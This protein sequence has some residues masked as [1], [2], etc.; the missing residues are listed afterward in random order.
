MRSLLGASQTPLLI[1]FGAALRDEVWD[2][3]NPLL[4]PETDNPEQYNDAVY[5]TTTK[6]IV[7]PVS[8]VD[9]YGRLL[10]YHFL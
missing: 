5:A 4:G 6:A 1:I 9:A 10:S 2:L 3:E 8:V 7:A